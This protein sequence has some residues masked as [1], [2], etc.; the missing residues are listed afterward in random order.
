MGRSALFAL[1]IYFINNEEPV[2]NSV[3]H[4]PALKIVREYR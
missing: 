1:F 2:V 3:Q 4:F